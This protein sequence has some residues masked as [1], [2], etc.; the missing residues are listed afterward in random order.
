MNK[1]T[2]ILF[3]ILFIISF[4]CYKIFVTAK[5]KYEAANKAKQLPAFTFYTI[6][7]N[8]AYT[9]DSLEKNKPIGLIYFNSG[10]EHCQYETEQFIKHKGELSHAHIL[11]VSDEPTEA[12]RE[13]DSSY[14]LQAYPFIKLLRD[15]TH[16]F[17]QTFGSAVVP[18]ILLYNHE[19]TLVKSFKGEVKP[20][21]IIKALTP[22]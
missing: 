3:A 8:V 9:N 7:N 15:S 21:A 16:S 20:E 22:Q 19:H 5:T 1:K 12:L 10:C 4:L 17:F 11:M 18:T 2:L 14:H 13:F 6:A